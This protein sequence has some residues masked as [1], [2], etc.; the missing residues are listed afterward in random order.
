M[1]KKVV[2]YADFDN[3]AKSGKTIR[4]KIDREDSSEGFGTFYFTVDGKYKDTE[5]FKVTF[6]PVKVEEEDEDEDE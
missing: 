3:K 4:F 6:E 2:A 5:R 1:A